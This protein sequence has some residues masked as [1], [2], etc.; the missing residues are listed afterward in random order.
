MVYSPGGRAATRN[1]PA[2]SVCTFRVPINA[3]PDTSTV[4][5]ATAP[6]LES[7]TVPCRPAVVSCAK[8][9]PASNSAASSASADFLISYPFL[10]E[11]ENQQT[12]CPE[13]HSG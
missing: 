10:V 5:L 11:A 1:P 8:E 13:R 7:L 2:E 12:L 4:P 9:M 6:P 3:G